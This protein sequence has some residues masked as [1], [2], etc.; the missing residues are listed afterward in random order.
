MAVKIEIVL[1]DSIRNYDV[2]PIQFDIKTW[3]DGVEI[4]TTRWVSTL[5]SYQ[6]W[7]GIHYIN[8]A[9]N[10]YLHTFHYAEFKGNIVR[11]K[12][13]LI[14]TAMHPRRHLELGGEIEDF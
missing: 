4:N 9:H 12:E 8:E 10:K 7:G 13:E 5:H 14:S 3:I 1:S 2:C 6:K 11:M